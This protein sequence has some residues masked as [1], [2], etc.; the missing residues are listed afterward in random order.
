MRASSVLS[1]A[2]L[3]AALVACSSS[4]SHPGPGTDAGDAGDSASPGADATAEAGQDTGTGSDAPGDAPGDA[5]PVLQTYV[6]V[7][8]WSPDVASFDFCVAPQG[9]SDW[10][11]PILAIAAALE[12]DA[13]SLGDGGVDGL[14]FPEVTEYL[15]LL[16]GAYDVRLVAAS[17]TDCSVGIAPDATG[18]P[19]LA[20]SAHS[21]IAVVGDS[22]VAGSDAPLTIEVLTDD[23]APPAAGGFALRFINAVPSLPTVSFG[24]G[25]LAKKTFAPLFTGVAFGAAGTQGES[26][27]GV[28]DGNGYLSLA[29]LSGDLS[30][31]ASGATTDTATAPGVSFGGGQVVTVAAV[32]G[33]THG[34]IPPELIACTDNASPVGLL[35][36]CV[37]NP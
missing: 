27:A 25:S 37:V 2:S 34:S 26:D 8:D 31:V 29:A 10:E 19:A 23:A 12:P 20:T 35:T 22:G 36:S 6:R 7:A 1:F 17:A 13:G 14:T 28:V 16:P 21:T 3:A 15:P 32:G 24:E 11:G 5:G 33:K 9:T 4:G 30:V 18:L